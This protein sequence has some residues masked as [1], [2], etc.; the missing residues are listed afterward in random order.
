MQ[1]LQTNFCNSIVTIVNPLKLKDAFLELTQT[2]VNEV[3]VE[4]SELV[5]IF[6]T[7]PN[8]N[9]GNKQVSKAKNCSKNNNSI[10]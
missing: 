2:I 9:V 6:R 7:K 4:R 1:A 5:C 8:T 10:Q 3:E